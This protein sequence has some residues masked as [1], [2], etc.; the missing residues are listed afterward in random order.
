MLGEKVWNQ[1]PPQLRLVESGSRY[2]TSPIGLYWSMR[3]SV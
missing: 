1:P 3:R 2:A